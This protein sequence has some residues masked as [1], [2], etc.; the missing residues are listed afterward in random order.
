MIRKDFFVYLPSDGAAVKIQDSG[1][2]IEDIHARFM[3]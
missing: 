2:K 1:E 3:D